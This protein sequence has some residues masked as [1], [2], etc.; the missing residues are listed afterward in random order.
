MKEKTINIK[1]HNINLDIKTF[2]FGS[3]KPNVLIFSGLHGDEDTGLLIC[4]DLI[5]KLKTKENNLKGKVTIIPTINILG[6]IFNRREDPI[7]SGD[8]NRII[9]K[10]TPETIADKLLNKLIELSKKHDLV[11][12]IHT[13]TE[14][15]PIIAIFMNM[16][17]ET[18]KK[19]SKEYI[20]TFGP[21]I[22][23]NLSP[24]KKDQTKFRNSFGPA[25]ASEGI[26]N[27]AIETPSAENITKEQRK[28]ITQGLLRILIKNQPTKPTKSV[29]IERKN[30]KTPQ[31][32]LFLPQVNLLESIEEGQVIGSLLRNDLSKTKIKAPAKGIIV[33]HVGTKQVREGELILGIGKVIK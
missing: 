21:N 3:G 1:Q 27:F 15:A 23:W 19:K 30:I 16:G 31:S 18:T 13:M 2:Q 26:N 24:E 11:I 14:H 22:I 12:D 10:T 29:E 9:G 28:R 32:G 20:N 5:K 33:N 6:R 7:S 4:Q 8:L 17:N 25:L